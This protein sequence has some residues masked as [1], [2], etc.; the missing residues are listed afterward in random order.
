MC[1]I[2]VNGCSPDAQKYISMSTKIIKTL[3]AK[4]HTNAHCSTKSLFDIAHADMVSSACYHWR[5]DDCILWI[6]VMSA[7][8]HANALPS[9]LLSAWIQAAKTIHCVQQ[10]KTTVYCGVIIVTAEEND[11]LQLYFY[12]NRSSVMWYKKICC[13]P[14]LIAW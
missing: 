3:S 13:S 6:W 9:M 7:I 11:Y 12:V 2:S 8:W 10:M 5:E 1:F 14:Y 4:I